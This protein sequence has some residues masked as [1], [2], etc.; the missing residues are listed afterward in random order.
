MCTDGDCLLFRSTHLRHR[1]WSNKLAWFTFIGWNL[2]IVSAVISFPLGLTQG[3]EYAELEWP[4]DIAIAVVWLSYM[5]NFIMTI[6]NR[7]TSHIYVSELVLPGHDG[8]DH[9]S[10]CGKQPRCSGWAV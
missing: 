2:I 6:A 8:D 9:L 7:K 4:I 10:A 5:F 3:K 1:L